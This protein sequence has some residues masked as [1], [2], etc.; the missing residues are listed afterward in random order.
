LVAPDVIDFDEERVA[1]LLPTRD[2]LVVAREVTVV[3]RVRAFELAIVLPILGAGGACDA[4][5]VEQ[6]L[7]RRLRLDRHALEIL[8]RTSPD[9]D[10][11]DH[12][13]L[14]FGV[15][16]KYI[17]QTAGWGEV[18]ACGR[19]GAHF[20]AFREKDVFH[21]TAFQIRRCCRS[22]L[23]KQTAACIKPQGATPHPPIESIVPANRGDLLTRDWN[24]GEY[25]QTNKP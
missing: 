23:R 18:K 20:K 8:P 4:E 13:I 25:S 14:H 11:P 24:T 1:A 6:L 19:W 5:Q 7:Q 9:P 10:L 16:G 12:S 3:L 21:S 2:P 15:Q 22:N 17:S